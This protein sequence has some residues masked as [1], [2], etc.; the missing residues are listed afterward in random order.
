M[1]TSI[2]CG[3]SAG[4]RRSSPLETERGQPES[5]HAA[6]EGQRDALAQALPHDVQAARAHRRAHREPELLMS[7]PRWS[8]TPGPSYLIMPG[9]D[10][11]YLR[12]PEENNG[13]YVRVIPDWVAQMKRAVDAAGP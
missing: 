3:S 5:G 4:A 2:D 8:D 11:V 13:H 10:I 9:G 7:E 6:H 1:P 12:A